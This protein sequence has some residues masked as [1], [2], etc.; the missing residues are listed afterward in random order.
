MEEKFIVGSI[1]LQITCSFGVSLLSVN[2]GQNS[3]NYYFLADKSLYVAKHSGK[4]R[5][6]IAEGSLPLTLQDGC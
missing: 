6:E 4:N 1:T 2:D 5:V 3:E